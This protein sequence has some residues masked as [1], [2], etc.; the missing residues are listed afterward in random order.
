MYS[1]LQN[2]ATLRDAFSLMLE[3]SSLALVRIISINEQNNTAQAQRL[4]THA[5][6][7]V[8][9][10][11]SVNAGDVW[12][13]FPNVNS[14][15]LVHPLHDDDAILIHVD[16]VY[17]AVF[18]SSK[19]MTIKTSLTSLKTILTL[20][21]EALETLSVNTPN[22]PSTGLAPTSIQKISHIRT[23]LHKLLSE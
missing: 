11:P 12:T 23:E 17:K 20:F 21:I 8:R 2:E 22:G 6:T 4:D 13:L 9:L 15:A 3:S 18:V 14:M 19:P 10:H 16:S 1:Q 7:R 5:H